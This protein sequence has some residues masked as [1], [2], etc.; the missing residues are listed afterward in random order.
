MKILVMG[1]YI[2]FKMPFRPELAYIS[3]ITPCLRW[4]CSLVTTNFAFVPMAVA[5]RADSYRGHPGRNS[6]FM[7]SQKTCEVPRPIGFIKG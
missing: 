7:S 3:T 4:R 6:W 2:G 1:W 5:T